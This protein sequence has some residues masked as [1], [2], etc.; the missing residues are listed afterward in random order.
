M[1]LERGMNQYMYGLSY[2]LINAR[3]KE[4]SKVIDSKVEKNLIMAK[5]RAEYENL[6]KVSVRLFVLRRERGRVIW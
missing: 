5:E 2:V 1:K 6:V 3:L 4:I